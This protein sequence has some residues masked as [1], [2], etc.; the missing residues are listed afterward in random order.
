[1]S[2]TGPGADEVEQVADRT[3]ADGL[4]RVAGNDG[5]SHC[6]ARG[7]H[8]E[9]PQLFRQGHLREQFLDPVH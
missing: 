3:A 7:R 5:T 9:L 2:R 4:G 8:G 1:M 6:I